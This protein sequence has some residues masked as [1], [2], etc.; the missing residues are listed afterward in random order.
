MAGPCNWTDLDRAFAL[1]AYSNERQKPI[2]AE[3][4]KS[5]SAGGALQPEARP[6]PAFARQKPHLAILASG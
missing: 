3:H 4:T 1:G 6:W 2:F 5:S